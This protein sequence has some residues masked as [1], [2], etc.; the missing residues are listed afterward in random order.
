MS[1][2]SKLPLLPLLF[3]LLDAQTE[4]DVSPDDQQQKKHQQRRAQALPLPIQWRNKSPMTSKPQKQQFHHR[5]RRRQ[6]PPS[7]TTIDH[8][9]LQSTTKTIDHS[10][11]QEQQQHDD[12]ADKEWTQPLKPTIK[13]D[14][15][16]PSA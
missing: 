10:L 16:R 15:G 2:T 6:C 3:D 5:C 1:S 11:L 7:T 13:M 8:L 14:H 4:A 12:D 9:L